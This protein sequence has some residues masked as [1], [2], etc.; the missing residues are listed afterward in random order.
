MEWRTDHALGVQEFA[1]VLGVNRLTVNRWESGQVDVPS[2]MAL[3]LKG[4]SFSHS[5]EWEC[6]CAQ[7]YRKRLALMTQDEIDAMHAHDLVMDRAHT[8]V[9]NA[10]RSR[11]AS[12]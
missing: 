11:A 12:K 6:C 3:A 8:R 5:G 9:I 2:F 4:L 7:C 1:T 10:R